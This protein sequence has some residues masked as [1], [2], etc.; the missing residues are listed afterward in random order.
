MSMISTIEK[1]RP[2]ISP[3]G[4]T[5]PRHMAAV[6]DNVIATVLSLIAAKQV[7][8]E[9]PFIVVAIIGFIG[10]R[11]KQR[12]GDLVARTIVVFRR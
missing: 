1:P 2:A 11:N 9:W 12:F 4:T 8:E 7:P 3:A 5:L 6:V 10:S